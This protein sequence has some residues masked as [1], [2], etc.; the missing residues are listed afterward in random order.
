ME[1]VELYSN[2]YITVE[3]RPEDKLIYHTVHRPMGENQIEMLKDALN[4]GTDA[5]GQYGVTKWLS[6]DRKNGPLPPEMAEWG[7]T[8]WNVRTI[9]AGWKY[10]ANVVPTQVAAAGA[11]IPVINDLHQHG[12]QMRVFTTVEDALDWLNSLD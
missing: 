8:D 11:L 9:E 3:Y 4:T 12:L 6:D 10:W 5:L 2:I 1:R 7:A